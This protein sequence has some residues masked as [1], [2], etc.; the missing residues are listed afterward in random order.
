MEE[1]Y[2]DMW[3]ALKCSVLKL[4]AVKNGKRKGS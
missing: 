4:K 2:V 3:T 1:P